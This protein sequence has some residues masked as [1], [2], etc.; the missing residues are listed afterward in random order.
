MGILWI[1]IPFFIIASHLRNL[2]NKRYHL[3]A[4]TTLFSFL[5]FLSNIPPPP[6]P[7]E[8]TKSASKVP[9]ILTDRKDP[10][11][12]IYH[13][14]FGSQKRRKK[15]IRPSTP[16]PLVSHS[17]APPPPFDSKDPPSPPSWL[18]RC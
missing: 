13:R 9:P 14:H 5:F 11:R 4:L 12:R 1:L 2:F 17:G 15:K 3:L 16:F 10:K 7:L 18:A 8:L 6:L